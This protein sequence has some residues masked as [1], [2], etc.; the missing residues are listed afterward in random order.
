MGNS[1][2]EDYRDFIEI[3]GLK[4]QVD[5]AK[6][7]AELGLSEEELFEF[8]NERVVKL[9]TQGFNAQNVG[10]YLGTALLFGYWLRGVHGS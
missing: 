5:V 4:E 9:E 2:E 3:Q 1:L 7:T 10:E 8:L 6:V